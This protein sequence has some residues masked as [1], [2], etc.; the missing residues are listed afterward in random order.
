MELVLTD[1]QKM[2]DQSARNFIKKASPVAR[3][4]E[5]RDDPESLG[6]DKAV[7]KQMAKLDWTA[8]LFPENLGGMGMGMADMVVVMEAIGAGLAPEPIIPSVILAGQLIALSENET[9]MNEWLDSIIEVKKV[10]AVAYQEKKGRYN[11]AQVKTSAERT[12]VGYILNGEKS[13]VLGGWGAD[14]VIVSAGTSGQSGDSDGLTLFLVPTEAPGVSITR[15]H[16][17]DSRNVALVRLENVSVSEA[18]ILGQVNKGGK[19]LSKVIDMATIT[20][21]GE[22]LGGMSAVFERTLTYLKE[23]IQFDVTIGSFQ[24]LQHRAARIFMEIELARSAVMAAARGYDEKTDHAAA[25]ISVAKARCSDA[26]ILATNEAVQMHGGIG[27]SDEED[28]G[29][30]MKH[31][32]AAELTFG[33]A[34]FHRDRFASI[35][36]Y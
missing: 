17:V 13:Q 31:A 36:G 33:D 9:L 15:Q 8:I 28:V 18:N 3:M 30:Y 23:R 1:E 16:R 20:L 25:L 11:I 7:F 35:K 24:C 5:L 14:A 12:D 29:L 6:Y 21:C 32:R 4:R 19:I 10:V 2:L 27:M 22:M 26:Y 34:G